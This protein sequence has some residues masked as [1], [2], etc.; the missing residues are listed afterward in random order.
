MAG[1][2]HSKNDQQ[3][4]NHAAAHL[5]AAGANPDGGDSMKAIQTKLQTL[6]IKP[7]YKALAEYASEEAWDIQTA[8]AVLAQLAQLAGSEADDADTIDT[9]TLSDAMDLVLAFIASEKAQMLA[10]PTP[11]DAMSMENMPT[12]DNMMSYG[13]E[14]KSLGDGHY[15]GY[16]VR[17]GSP[18]DTDADGEYFDANT[19]FG[20]SKGETIS[21][22]VWLNHC[23]PLRFG[24]GTKAIAIREPIGN[25][26]VKMVDDGILIDAILFERAKYEKVLDKLGWSSG[27]A[28]HTWRKTRNGK[29]IHI[30]RWHLGLD[31]SMTPKHADPRNTILPIKSL[32]TN[33][34]A[35]PEGTLTNVS[36]Q[37]TVTASDAVNNTKNA[38]STAKENQDMEE[39]QE[40]LA[41]VNATSSNVKS[42]TSRLDAVEKALKAE[43]PV[44]GDKSG[45]NVQVITDE[46]D[47]PFKSLAA[48]CNALREYEVSKHQVIAPRIKYLNFKATG[49]SEGIPTDGGLLV[50]P[51]LTSEMIKPIHQTGVFSSKARRLPVSANSNYG[52]INGVDETS[53]ATGS[54]WGGIRGYRVAEAATKT[55]SKPTFRRINWELKEYACLVVATDQLLQDAAMF[56][57]IVNQGCREELSFMLNDDIMNGI[58]SSGAQGFMQSGALISFAR[59]DANKIQGTDISAMWNRMDLR[60]RATAEW[61]I[62]NDS[63]PQLD[64]LFAVGSTAVLY[65]YASIGADGVQRLYGKPINVTEFNPSLGTLGDIVLADMNQYLTWEKSDVEAQTSIHVYFTTDET[66][67]RFVYRSDGKSSVASALTPYKGTTTTSPFVALTAAS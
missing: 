30:D 54:R 7:A 12:G 27:T 18:S 17:F 44:N 11:S 8:T 2:R 4:I 15:G 33:Q 62:G 20:F 37:A 67:F 5:M 53:R 32:A 21:S 3:H 23:Q 36:A 46:A 58:G 50:D 56:S 29:S 24:D 13:G 31:A 64:N 49:A 61:F 22:P 35:E 1:A 45:L 55:G 6:A 14:I 48:Q 39:L 43:P 10:A 9:Q 60:G 47:R 66:A 59:L 19:D 63:Q 41:A 16:L 57:E 38:A 34:E 65:P 25:S 28:D 51:T 40:I 42:F 26:M 52:W